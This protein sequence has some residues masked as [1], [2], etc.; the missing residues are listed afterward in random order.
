MIYEMIMSRQQSPAHSAFSPVT[1]T[2]R[3]NLDA[4]STEAFAPP[5]WLFCHGLLK[6]IPQGEER[7][8]DLF[9]LRLICLIAETEN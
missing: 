7:E 4:V 9:G 6:S 1:A 3:A 5:L 2:I 8:I